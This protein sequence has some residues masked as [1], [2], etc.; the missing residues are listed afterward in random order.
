MKPHYQKILI[1]MAIL[2]LA[3]TTKVSEWML[4]N[5]NA[6]RYLL[7]YYHK[8]A[9]PESVRL[10]NQELEKRTNR[11]NI[12]FR[13]VL[14]ENTERPYYALYYKNR[15]FS[16]Y[17]DYHT[18]NGITDSPLRDKIAGELME[19]KLCVM[20][21]LTTGNPGKDQI[22]L[23]VLKKSI[24]ASPFRNIISMLELNRNNMEEN[25]FVSMLL[26]AEE[27]LKDIREPMLFGIFGRF[28]VLEPLL[29]KGISEENIHLMIDF[30]TADCS[31]IIKENLPG[32]SILYGGSW[33][34]PQPAM[35][36]KILDENPQLIHFN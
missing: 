15:L 12:L 14:K 23:Q 10:Q 13:Q 9:I 20:L 36:N 16:E 32:I 1:I 2:S 28:R 35:V 19:G 22:G 25:H 27:D 34:N 29:S 24:A 4:L 5:S 31:C 18:L 8:G 26:H 21:Y 7:V 33:E 3:C 11:A 17:G 6:D 30:L